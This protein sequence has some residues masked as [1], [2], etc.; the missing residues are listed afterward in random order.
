MTNL[1]DFIKESKAHHYIELKILNKIIKALNEADDPIVTVY[2][3]DEYTA[4]TPGNKA[5]IQRLVFNLD[6][7][8]LITR[9]GGYVFFVLG[10][11]WDCVSDYTLS[12][13]PVLAPINDFIDQHNN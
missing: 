10:N 3:T 7:C 9:S 2:D 1:D 12:L 5:E 8:Y 11:E 13:E 6:L 4:V